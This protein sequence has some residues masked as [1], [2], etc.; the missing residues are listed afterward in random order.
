[1][2]N[3][4]WCQFFI[5]NKIIQLKEILC[6]SGVKSPYYCDFRMMLNYN[7]KMGVLIELMKSLVEEEWGELS[8][9]SGENTELN[10]IGSVPLGAVPFATLLS[11]SMNKPSIMVRKEAKKYGKKNI[12]EGQMKVDD[13]VVMVEDVITTGGEVLL[14]LL[15]KLKIEVVMLK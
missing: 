7:D 14:K 5:K 1:M 3:K 13:N 15:R 2:T 8:F 4:E 12:I 6:S 10:R 9:E 11:Q